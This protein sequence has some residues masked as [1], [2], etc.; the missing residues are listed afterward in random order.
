MYTQKHVYTHT[1]ECMYVCVFGAFMLMCV[2]QP[3][4][5][6]ASHKKD[7][8]QSISFAFPPTR[9]LSRSCPPVLRHV[10]IILCQCAGRFDQITSH[11]DGVN[12]LLH[13]HMSSNVPLP[14]NLSPPSSP[15]ASGASSPPS[16]S[17]RETGVYCTCSVTTALVS[18]FT[19]K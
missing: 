1:L 11:E 5:L 14:P 7:P 2:C 4:S 10:T 15:P 8:L 9:G 17:M 6:G 16:S 3:G 19:K 18:E 12:L 13:V